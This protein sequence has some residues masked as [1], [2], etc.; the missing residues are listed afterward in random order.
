MLKLIEIAVNENYDEFKV[1][2]N[3]KLEVLFNN[4]VWIMTDDDI[5]EPSINLEW[6]KFS[7]GGKFKNSDNNNKNLQSNSP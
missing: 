2:I 6:N 7:D 1:K 3:S 4:K 5:I